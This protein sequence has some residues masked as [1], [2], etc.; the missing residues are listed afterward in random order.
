[1]GNIYFER[2]QAIRRMMADNGWDAV[3]IGAS[4]PHSSEY[5][6]PR[7]QAVQWVSGFTGE[8]GDIVITADHAGLWTDSRYFIQALEQLQG[9]G[10]E[11]HKTRQ[12]D[13]VTIP[14]W[15]AGRAGIVAVDGTCMSV[16]YVREIE[17]AVASAQDDRICKV[18]DVPDMLDSLWTDR[19]RIP[20]SPIVTIGEDDAGESRQDKIRWLRNFLKD[21]GCTSVL[22]SSLD[23]IAWLLNVRGSDIEYNPFVISYLYVSADDIIWFVQKDNA[24]IPDQD[25]VDSFEELRSDG[26]EIC[27]YD[28]TGVRLAAMDQEAGRMFIDPSAMNDHMY[29]YVTGIF[30]LDGIM[31]GK[32]PVALRK[33][34][35]NATEIASMEEVYLQDGVAMECFLHWLDTRVKAGDRVT[36][37][38]AAVKLGE[39]RSRI[40]GYRGDSF[41]TIS[42]YGPN[43]ALPHYSTPVHGSSVL[44][45]HGLYLVDSGGQY[46]F[47]TTD[48]TRTVP[49]GECTSLEME[50]YTLVLK[51]MIQLSM[52]VFPAC[53]A[54][55][56]LDVLARNALWKARRNFGHGTGHGVGFYLGV[57][58]GPQSIRQDF[59]SQ[60][61]LPGMV[62]SDEP[63]IYRQGQH[64]V[65]HEN[66]LLCEDAGTNSFGEWRRFKTLTVCHIDTSPIVKSMITQEE[67]EWLDSYN[68]SVYERLSPLLPAEVSVWL[69]DRISPFNI[70]G[71]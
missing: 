1:M 22:L 60:P 20:V 6:A 9:T 69:K 52:A 63:G 40:E 32:S 71:H 50:D 23:E 26:V 70:Q 41:A 16:S 2:V 17:K 19:P 25:T 36:E 27:S 12:P 14:E 59:N 53:T 4:D 57:H 3:V 11:L 44:E 61:L 55:C 33:A 43:A 65:R 45:N 47:G 15:L 5:P 62:T 24:R 64:G 56:Q 37:W 38:D 18:V 39:F 21:S 13:S 31:T 67:A 68:A 35:K 7:W 29:R 30:G 58:E 54:G 46:C 42:A 66:I 48:I 28:E 10:I 34:V 49:L 8:A 51:G